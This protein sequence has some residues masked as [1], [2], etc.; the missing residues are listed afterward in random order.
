[1]GRGAPGPKS[2]TVE[3]FNVLYAGAP[4]VGVGNATQQI[5]TDDYEIF[6]VIVRASPDNSGRVL[7]GNEHTQNFP[8]DA[9][10]SITIPIDDLRKV[11]VRFNTDNDEV[12]WLAMGE[13]YG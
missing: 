13:L 11:Y 7:I 9:G 6:Q 5:A 2:L 10:D 4:V 12:N 3:Y 1:M 8:L